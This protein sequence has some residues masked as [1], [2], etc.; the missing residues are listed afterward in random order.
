MTPFPEH[1]RSPA[2]N[3]MSNSWIIEDLETGKAL[4]ETNSRPYAERIHIYHG[5][6]CRVWTAYRW[7]QHLNDQAV[8][9]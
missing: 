8:A 1:E 6:Q 5:H 4:C 2:G 3:P 9:P 7:L